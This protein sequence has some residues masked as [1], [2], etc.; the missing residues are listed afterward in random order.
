MDI[1]DLE[2]AMANGKIQVIPA[3]EDQIMADMLVTELPLEERDLALGVDSR[4]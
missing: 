3:M 4:R 1:R 2:E